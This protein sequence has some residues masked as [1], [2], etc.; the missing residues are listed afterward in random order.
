MRVRVKVQASSLSSCTGLLAET[1]LLGFWHRILI[2]TMSPGW[3]IHFKSLDEGPSVLD[4]I[5]GL[6]E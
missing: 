1:K 6:E 5:N 3:L 2:S 4:S